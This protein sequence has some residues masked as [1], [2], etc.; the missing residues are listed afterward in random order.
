[1]TFECKDLE[2]ALAVPE[3]LPE[4]REH[5]KLCGA[6]RRELWL[7]SEM[8]N[9]SHGLREEWE[10][11]ELWPRIREALAAQQKAAKPRPQDWRLLAGLAAALVVAVSIFILALSRPAPA[12]RQDSDFLTE[13]AL[14]E[15][16]RTESAYRASIEKLS[17][18]AASKLSGSENPL[19]IASREK[20]LML[21][22][23]ISDVRSTV[24]HNRFNSKLQSEL[25]V[26]YRE[27]QDTLKEILQSAQK[28]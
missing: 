1:M 28:N 20:L 15:V 6:C 3:L 22:G 5:A 24:E 25:A 27:K 9:A 16:E 17:R 19:T 13:Q 23:E 18:L 7:W 11:P 10:S 12:P 2:R 4:A 21:D 14:R 8:S 26:L